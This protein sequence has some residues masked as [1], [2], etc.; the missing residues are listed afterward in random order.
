MIDTFTM[1]CPVCGDEYSSNSS[2]ALM[3]VYAAHSEEHTTDRKA[4]D[5]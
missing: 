1:Q 3:L 5:E 2:D 4:D